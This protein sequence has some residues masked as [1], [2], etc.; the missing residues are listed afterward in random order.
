MSDSWRIVIRVKQ[1]RTLVVGAENDAPNGL[2]D[3]IERHGI[4]VAVEGGKQRRWVER[5]RDIRYDNGP[6][7]R[8]KT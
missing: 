3:I 1:G 4:A 2:P 8:E 6:R 7:M 5:Y